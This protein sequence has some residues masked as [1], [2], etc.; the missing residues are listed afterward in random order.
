MSRTANIVWKSIGIGIMAL[1]LIAAVVGGYRMTPTSTPCTSLR[2]IIED[3]D[4]R[5][6]LSENE[7]TQ[8]LQAQDLYPVG[9]AQNQI[10]LARV[11]RT[12]TNHPMVRTAECYLTPRNEVRVRITQRV[13][14]LRVQT[15][16]E[17]YF[18]DT[19]RRIMPVRAAVRDSVLS[20]RGTVGVHLAAGQLADFAQWLQNEPYW[21]ARIR[22]MQVLSPRMIH[23]YLHGEN[24]PRILMGSMVGYERKLA[25][26]R[27]FLEHSDEQII[28]KHYS[29]LDL[30][31]RGQVI[32]RNPIINN[33]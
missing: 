2:Y 20:V 14:L 9:R 7:L 32:G 25:K 16:T 1:M 13:P 22:F 26:L 10:S 11:E 5:M 27:T 18:I 4:E 30:R 15:G 24:Q 8:M 21:Q 17:T 23:I 3:R 33:P 12:I 29:E 19:D 28:N 31:F 6:Y